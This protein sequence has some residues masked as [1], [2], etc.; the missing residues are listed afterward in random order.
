[1][2]ISSIGILRFNKD[3]EDAIIMDIA[4]N[5]VEYNFFQKGSVKEFLSFANKTLMKRLPPGVQ[6]VDYEGNLCYCYVTPDGLGGIAICDKEYPARVAVQM[7]KELVNNFKNE[8]GTRWRQITTDCLAKFPAL[9]QALKEYQE[10]TK[11]DKVMKVEKQLTETK[12]ILYKTIDAVL[13]RGEKLDDL[14]DKSSALSAQ[15]K[16]FYKQAK[17]TNSCCEVM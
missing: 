13:A 8:Y 5:L 16:M 15:S 12:D 11:V 17:K 2:K 7:V 3:T 14:V 4:Y 10:P 1:M 9:E 6:A